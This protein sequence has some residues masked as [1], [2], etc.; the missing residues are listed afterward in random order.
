MKPRG[1]RQLQLN[2]NVN[3]GNCKNLDGYIYLRKKTIN[4]KNCIRIT[5]GF[6]KRNVEEPLTPNKWQCPCVLQT[7]IKGGLGYFEETK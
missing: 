3:Q 4:N 1:W 5:K 6:L 2:K 7:G